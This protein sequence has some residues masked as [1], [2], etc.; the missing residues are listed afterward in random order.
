MKVI[1]HLGKS[2]AHFQITLQG[3]EFV[4]GEE[5][6][7]L[8]LVGI[9][10][11]ASDEG[12]KKIVVSI[13]TPRGEIRCLSVFKQT[14]TP[15]F[16]EA[17]L[18]GAALDTKLVMRMLQEASSAHGATADTLQDEMLAI[19]IAARGSILLQ[20]TKEGGV[21]VYLKVGMDDG[22]VAEFH[23]EVDG[24]V[25]NPIHWCLRAREQTK[26]VSVAPGAEVKGGDKNNRIEIKG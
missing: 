23:G 10:N 1:A 8:V 2:L 20:A 21:C 6:A 17:V 22:T 4:D 11:T 12:A 19:L 25:N 3:V 7:H 15:A 14:I 13:A 5:G 24:I 18:E 9:Q 26:G 16:I